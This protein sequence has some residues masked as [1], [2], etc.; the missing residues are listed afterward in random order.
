MAV[1]IVILRD[2]GLKKRNSIKKRKSKTFWVRKLFKERKSSRFFHVL[3]KELEMFDQ[4]YFLRFLRISPNRYE[5]MLSIVYPELQCQR[6]HF[7]E[8]ISPSERLTLTLRYL[9]SGESQQSLSFAFRISCTA[10]SNILADTCEK[11][12]KTLSNTVVF[13]IETSHFDWFLYKTQ[14]LRSC[15]FFRDRLVYHQ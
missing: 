10:L 14:H 6:T 8:P 9:A 5:H 15:T 4:E 1:S 11:I 3:T 2:D 7:R 13:H 12:W